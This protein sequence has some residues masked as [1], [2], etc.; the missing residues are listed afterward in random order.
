MNLI[1]LDTNCL[2]DVE[3]ERQG[4]EYVIGL[5]SLCQQE[6]IEIAIPAIIASEKKV[7]NQSITNFDEFKEFLANIGFEG[8][9]L[10]L[11]PLFYGLTFWDYSMWAS[12]ETEA[13]IIEIHN[14]LFNKSVTFESNDYE[15]LTKWKN[16]KCDVL[17]LWSHIHY[18]RDFFITR[19]RNFHKQSKKKDLIKLGAKSI[20]TPEEAFVYFSKVG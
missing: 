14:I 6:I 10:L 16:E 5:K 4:Y 9:Q 2:I 19:D 17:M 18:Q 1:T 20:L 12:K 15:N 8:F 3:E 11:P 7:K 13:L